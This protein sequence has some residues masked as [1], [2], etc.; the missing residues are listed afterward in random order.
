MNKRS[1]DATLNLPKTTM[2]LRF[3][4]ADEALVR[5]QI[6]TSLYEALQSREK[7]ANVQ[8]IDGPPF[9]NGN[10]HVGKKNYIENTLYF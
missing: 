8:L 6:G 5:K 10:L 4:A 2:P 7:E 9:A 3:K 1:W